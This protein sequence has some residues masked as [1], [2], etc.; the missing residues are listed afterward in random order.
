M[1]RALAGIALYLVAASA[2]AQTITVT[3]VDV[4]IAGLQNGQYILTV[5]G[6]EVT[7]HP[8]DTPPIPPRPDELSPRAIA[9]RDAALSVAGDPQRQESAAVLSSVLRE[10]AEQV[11]GGEI[12]GQEQVAVAVKYAFRMGLDSSAVEAAWMPVRDVIGDQHA[13]LAQEGADDTA[14]VVWMDEVADGL[15][16]AAGDREQIDIEMILKIVKLILAILED[17]F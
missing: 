2:A 6:A 11:R 1:K 17:L 15:A 5:N 10:L 3:G 9:V 7:I 4:Q 13:K 16:A 14:F 8:T 12:T